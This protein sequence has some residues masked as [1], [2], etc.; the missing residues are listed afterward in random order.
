MIRVILSVGLLAWMLASGGR[1][2]AK[3]KIAILG[4]EVVSQGSAGI[5]Q[6]ST[7]VAAE[8]TVGLRVRPK[9][10]QGPFQ[11]TPGSEK[12]LID[13]KL[14]NG[15][16]N[17]EKTCMA[18]IGKK[19]GAE[20][21][22]YGKIERKSQG[23]KSGYQISLRLLKIANQ[24][25]TTWTDFIP[26]DESKDTKLQDWAR[27]GYKKLTNENDG[28]TLVINAN[29]DRGTI[30]IEGEERG[31]IS[32][33]KGEVSGLTEGRYKVSV[34]ST[35]YR[36]WDFKDELSIRNGE[37]TTEQVVLKELKKGGGELCDPMLSTCENTIGDGKPKTGFWKGMMFTGLAIAAGG[38]GYWY[39]SFSRIDHYEDLLAAEN[40]PAG[41]P[42]RT[43]LEGRGQ[44]FAD[45]TAIGIAVVSVGGVIATI[46]LIKGYIATGGEKRAAGS[47]T[48]GRS[49]K[50]P[51]GVTVTP[52]VGAQT[53]G[54]LLRLDW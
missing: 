42:R 6:E 34:V 4:L 45:H 13:E 7:K 32:S 37:T 26:L 5:D 49:R 44:K 52:V 35:G 1:A 3:E 15:C 25:L 36:R 38:A 39:Y 33:G 19:L 2:E 16:D 10:G 40:P 48:V 31:N 47:T 24:A 46:G 8:L 27:K 30:L 43:F 9:S 17:E 54:A 21:L 41:D 22:M 50:R 23:N 12:E 14:M 11:W 28:G 51:S 29:V 18:A 20:L 53:A